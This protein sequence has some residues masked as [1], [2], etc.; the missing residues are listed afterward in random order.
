MSSI[1]APIFVI[2]P[3]E[4]NEPVL[5]L[6]KILGS[7]SEA[8]V[9]EFENIQMLPVGYHVD[10]YAEFEGCFYQQKAM[11]KE[12]A[13]TKAGFII[14]LKRIGPRV[15]AEKRASHRVRI[16]GVPLTGQIGDEKRCTITDISPEGF[17]AVTKKAFNFGTSVP[18]CIEHDGHVLEGPAHLQ[19]M[20]RLPDG[21]FRCGFLIPEK[22][23]RMRRPLERIASIMQRLELRTTAGYRALDS[24]AE[25]SG[26]TIRAAIEGMGNSGD[27]IAK[28]LAKQGIEAPQAEE[29]YNQQAWLDALAIIADKYG[30][31][32]LYKIGFNL[33]E[34]LPF[35]SDINS[36][37]EALDILDARF[38]M[39]HRKGLIGHYY[40]GSLGTNRYEVVCENSYPCDFDKGL[41]AAYC[42]RFKPQGMEHY[43]EPIHDDSKPCRKSGSDSCTFLVTW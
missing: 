1:G 21:K 18:I 2:V 6:G 15:S 8:F 40:L 32:I 30:P 20:C 23:A 14:T 3:N 13:R 43:A 10:A 28:I 31:D 29:W 41:L 39:N 42:S 33:P 22:N 35:P 16:L 7:S 11:V 36:L 4:T 27:A 9:A 26:E 17:A 34:H 25:V 37:E 24:N 5:H 38:H 19:S 12:T